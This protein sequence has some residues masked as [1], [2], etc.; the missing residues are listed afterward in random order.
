VSALTLAELNRGWVE[1]RCSRCGFLL[2]GSPTLHVRCRCGRRARRFLNGTALTGRD[3]SRL[4]KTRTKSLQIEGPKMSRGV[5]RP[6][7]AQG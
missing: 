3:A 2:A 7:K 6:W 1:F 4:E 5:L